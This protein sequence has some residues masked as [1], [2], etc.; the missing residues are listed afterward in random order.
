MLDAPGA[1]L[2]YQILSQAY[3]YTFGGAPYSF[4]NQPS[5]VLEYANGTS[6]A[7]GLGNASGASAFDLAVSNAN[8]SSSASSSAFDIGGLNALDSVQGDLTAAPLTANQA[9]QIRHIGGDPYSGGNGAV[10]AQLV[11]CIVATGPPV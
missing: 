9:M 4:S 5:N 1:N 11:Y 10:V 3:F 6:T 7:V 2:S 8:G